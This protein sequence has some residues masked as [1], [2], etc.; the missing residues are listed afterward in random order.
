MLQQAG[1]FRPA[2]VGLVVAGALL[3]YVA[4]QF[5][6]GGGHPLS[7]TVGF[8]LCG[9]LGPQPA[10]DLPDLAATPQATIPDAAANRFSTCYWP[11]ATGSGAASPREVS[12]VLMTHQALRVQGI[13]AGT[14]KYVETFID[15]SRASGVEVA[16][17][18]GPW[19]SGFTLRS[20]GRK[21]IDLLVEDDGVVL[22]FSSRGI[23]GA[24]L[25]AFA[26]AAARRL[27]AKS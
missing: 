7:T 5:L 20:P 13:H 16:A 12:L 27:R 4:V 19:R 9:R 1:R 25:L 17:A 10:Q 15:E 24:T 22:Q 26:N 11:I 14:A 23:E 6:R 21:E 2:G 3:L 18:N 8:D